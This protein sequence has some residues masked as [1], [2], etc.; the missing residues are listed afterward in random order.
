MTYT[1]NRSQREVQTRYLAMSSGAS[2]LAYTFAASLG[3]SFHYWTTI[4]DA[5]GVSE[6]AWW[7]Q[8]DSSQPSFGL[9]T[10][11][12]HRPHHWPNI[13]GSTHVDYTWLT[14]A[15]A[16]LYLSNSYTTVASTTSNH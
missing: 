8:N 12:E 16:R 10:A 5:D 11:F 4:D 15:L 13:G 2:E 3:N 9:Q 7:F 1:G 14:D 6:K